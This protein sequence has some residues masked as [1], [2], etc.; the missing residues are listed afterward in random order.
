MALAL[1]GVAP[2]VSLDSAPEPIAYDAVPREPSAEARAQLRLE[3][4]ALERRFAPVFVQDTSPAHPERDRPLPVDFDRDWD[5]QN[6]WSHLRAEDARRAPVVYTS[7]ILTA[8]HAYLTYTLFFP[9]DWT[10]LPCVPYLCHDNDLES[11]LV[12][13]S[14]EGPRGPADLVLV[15]TKFHVRFAAEPAAE[16]ARGEAG[17]P[18]VTV[19]SE[20]HGMLPVRRGQRLGAYDLRYVEQSV[21]GDGSAVQRYELVSL[22]SSLWARRAPDA[23]GSRLWAPGEAGFLSYSGARLGPLGRALGAAMSG[24][25]YAGGVRP[26]WAIRADGRRGD[27]FFDP[28]FV[29][30]ARYGAWFKHPASSE[31]VLNTYVDDLARECAGPTCERARDEHEAALVP[32]GG[33]LTGLGLLLLRSG[34]R[35]PRGSARARA[36]PARR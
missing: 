21:S 28:A 4:A 22:E 2:A 33:L 5:A 14:R 20:G 27:W 7:S 9:R 16:L 8:T 17:R 15:E 30:L 18:I 23:S 19:E 26:P 32:P 13:V 6:N 25:E 29:A 3:G 11:L 12:V 10:A 31:Y 34:R 24:R 36:L 35:P 1:T